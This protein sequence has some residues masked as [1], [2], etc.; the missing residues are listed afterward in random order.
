[1]P[2]RGKRGVSLH[3]MCVVALMEL[4]GH[5]KAV[6]HDDLEAKLMDAKCTHR[7]VA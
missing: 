2:S 1:M 3:D 7:W 5:T 4:Q 6:F